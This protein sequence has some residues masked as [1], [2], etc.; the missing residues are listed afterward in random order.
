MKIKLNNKH[1]IYIIYA[2]HKKSIFNTS[3]KKHKNI[4][5]HN[6]FI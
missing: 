6:K 2:I 3:H 4:S 5:I 1:I